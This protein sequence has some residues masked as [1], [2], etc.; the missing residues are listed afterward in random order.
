MGDDARLSRSFTF[1][2]FHNS[3]TCLALL[4]RGR[5]QVSFNLEAF[6]KPLS[7]RMKRQGPPYPDTHLVTLKYD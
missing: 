5:R 3:G 7:Q 2:I 4:A 1:T 6:S